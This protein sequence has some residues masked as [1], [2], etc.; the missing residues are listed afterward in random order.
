LY[1]EAMAICREE[2]QP[3]MLAHTVR[4]VGDIHRDARR[5]ELG[6]L[7][8]LEALSIYRNNEHTDTLDLANAIRPLAIIKNAAGEVEEATHRW[9]RGCCGK[10]TKT[11]TGGRQRRT[12]ALPPVCQ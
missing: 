5:A 11:G 10:F 3:L 4:H 8:Y 6:E 2:D 9:A 7:C 1:E 12:G